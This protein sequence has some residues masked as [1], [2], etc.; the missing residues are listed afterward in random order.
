MRLAHL[1]LR[2]VSQTIFFEALSSLIEA[3]CIRQAKAWYESLL[4]T[5]IRAGQLPIAGGAM[6]KKKHRRF[7]GRTSLH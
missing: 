6:N 5:D 4:V 7:R 2:S 1:D 3:C